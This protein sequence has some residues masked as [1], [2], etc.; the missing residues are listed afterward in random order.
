MHLYSPDLSIIIPA[1]QEALRLPKTL[2]LV[3]KFFE[4]KSYNI[5]IIPV[6]Q[7]HD[8]T[9][10]FVAAAAAVDSR[11]HPIFDLG[12]HGK[13]RAVRLGMQAAQGNI[14][15]F[16][17]ADLSV[18]LPC[19]E[20]LIEKFLLSPSDDL[21]IGSRHLRESTI[22]TP[23]TFLRHILGR[24]LNLLLRLSGLTCFRDTQCG[25]KLFRHDAAQRI[26]A[27]S[28]M[29][30]FAF[31][32]EILL[33]AKKLGYQIKEVPVTWANVGN[34]RLRLLRDGLKAL[35]DIWSLKNLSL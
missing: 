25:C 4:K 20:Q 35:K 31:D 26:F 5:E 28:I 11:I 2:S 24:A 23:Q 14:I 12:G 34:S 7:G 27:L 29:D 18:P 8:Q 6:I 22:L 9:A 21:F 19:L 30:G 32:V 17:D 16:M 15:L 33:L 13:G 1:R 10:S 3:Q